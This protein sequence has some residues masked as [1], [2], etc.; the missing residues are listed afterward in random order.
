[1]IA[2]Q[3]SFFPLICEPGMSPFNILESQF[4][5]VL[6]NFE[7]ASLESWQPHFWD[8]YCWQPLNSKLEWSFQIATW[9][10]RGFPGEGN[11]ALYGESV[12]WKLWRPL[13]ISSDLGPFSSD[14]HRAQRSAGPGRIAARGASLGH[15]FSSL[16]LKNRLGTLKY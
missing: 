16:T 2:S 4:L 3:M 9:F 15:P 10:F 13:C 6:L 14:P 7:E 11:L 5:R 1:M 12:Q 8:H